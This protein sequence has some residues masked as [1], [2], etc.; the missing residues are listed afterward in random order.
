VS[1]NCS[2][3]EQKSKIKVKYKW[4]GKIKMIINFEEI[5]LFLCGKKDKKEV[6]RS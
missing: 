5:F 2:N 3:P 6:L 1:K 4:R